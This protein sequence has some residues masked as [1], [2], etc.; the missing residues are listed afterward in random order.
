VNESLSAH[1]VQARNVFATTVPACFDLPVTAKLLAASKSVDVIIVLGYYGE[2]ESGLITGAIASG[3][4][5]VIFI[6]PSQL[7]VD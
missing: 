5:Q 6:C 2:K 3:T 7:K 1:G 4:L